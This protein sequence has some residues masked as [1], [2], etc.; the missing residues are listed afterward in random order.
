MTARLDATNLPVTLGFHAPTAWT[1]FRLSILGMSRRGA[2]REQ[3]RR[4]PIARRPNA[5]GFAKHPSPAHEKFLL[6]QPFSNSVAGGRS[7]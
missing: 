2:D 6:S 1:A 7:P 5:I 3:I 4:A